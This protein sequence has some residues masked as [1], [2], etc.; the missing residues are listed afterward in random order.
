MTTEEAQSWIHAVDYFT[1]DDDGLQHD[2]W[3][4]VWLN[5]PYAQPLISRFVE[6]AIYEYEC[7]N[8]TSGVRPEIRSRGMTRQLESHSRHTLY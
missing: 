6:K 3:D 8:A 1:K 5:P 7:G 4:S 2:L